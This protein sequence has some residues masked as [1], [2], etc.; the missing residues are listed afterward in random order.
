M[1]NLDGGIK[2]Q[3]HPRNEPPNIE[4]FGMSVGASMQGSIDLHKIT[5]SIQL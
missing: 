2:F 3:I 5:V 4:S 1:G